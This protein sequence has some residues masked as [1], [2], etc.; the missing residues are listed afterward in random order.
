MAR[1]LPISNGKYTITSRFAGRTNP[2]TGRPENHS[3]TD[4]AAPDGTPFYAVASEIG[5]AHV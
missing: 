1:Y 2:I 4:F 3:G 5:R